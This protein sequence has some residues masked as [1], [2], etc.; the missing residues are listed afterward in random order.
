MRFALEIVEQTRAA[1]GDDFILIFRIAAM[2]MLED[3]MSWEEIITLGKAL[4]KAGVTIISTHFTWHESAVPTIAT[5][6]PRAAVH[7]GEWRFALGIER[8]GHPLES[9]QYARCRR[10]SSRAR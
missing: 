8:S 6:V 4:E 10:R 9:N 2:D 3:G 7:F 1:V 5:M